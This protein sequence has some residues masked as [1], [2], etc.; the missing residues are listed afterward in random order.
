MG[1]AAAPASAVAPISSD[2]TLSVNRERVLMSWVDGQERLLLDLDLTGSV[3]EDSLTKLFLATPGPAEIVTGDRSALAALDGAAQAAAPEVIKVDRWWPD[4]ESFGGGEDEES[5]DATGVVSVS[6]ADD[7]INHGDPPA[8]AMVAELRRLGLEVPDNTSEVIGRYAAAGWY[9]TAITVEVPADTSP[10]AVTPIELTF[11]VESP[12]V[13]LLLNASSSGSLELTTYVLG[14]ERMDR[15][16]PMR[17]PSTTQFSGTV[18]AAEH[19]EL[20][21]WLEPFG[22]RAVLTAMQQTFQSPG[23]IRDDIHFAPS[24]FGPID[25]GTETVTVDR[26]IFG[27]PAGIVLVGAGMI[28]VAILGVTISQVMQ[29]R[30][31]R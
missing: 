2:G 7:I 15:T 21:D 20:A 3:A 9:F 8:A 31:R 10:W 17:G 18:T 26:I 13:P 4:L 16:D 11:P 23:R 12:I 22:G 5:S 6:G 30:Y 27:L 28:A 29:R 1:L 14:T 24:D 25:A 19:P